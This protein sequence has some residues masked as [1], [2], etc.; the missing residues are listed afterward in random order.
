MKKRILTLGI[1]LALVMAMV[2][3][4]AV[5]AQDTSIGTG[6]IEV[7]SVEIIPPG[8]FGFGTF[9]FGDDNKVAATD[10]E[11]IISP[12][13]QNPTGMTCTVTAKDQNEVVGKMIELGDVALTDELLISA[14]AAISYEVASV[15]VTYPDIV[16]GLFTFDA[17]QVITAADTTAGE[18][19][20]TIVFTAVINLP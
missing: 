18:Y 13:S 2:I 5:L 17:S 12:G 3:P 7:A 11:V 9:A 19:T 8:P 16:D 4:T 10:G 14:D 6:T 15:G 1:V 20:I